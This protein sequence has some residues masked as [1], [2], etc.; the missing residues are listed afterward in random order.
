MSIVFSLQSSL[1]VCDRY[2]HVERTLGPRPYRLDLSDSRGLCPYSVYWIPIIDV[3][4]HL[5]PRIFFGLI[6]LWI[7]ILRYDNRPDLQH[8][9]RT[10]PCT[11]FIIFRDSARLL[12]STFPSI[13]LSKYD[14]QILVVGFL[15]Y[16]SHDRASGPIPFPPSPAQYLIADPHA[17]SPSSSLLNAPHDHTSLNPSPIFQTFK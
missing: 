14:Q 11:V 2:V 7:R 13:S 10:I 9:E 6:I 15:S 1:Y 4:T 17:Y 3:S 16:I 8:L 5:S 12:R